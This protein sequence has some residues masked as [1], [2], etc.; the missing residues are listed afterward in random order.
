MFDRFL[1]FDH[2]STLLPS[3]SLLP[4]S[5]SFPQGGVAGLVICLFAK[6][7]DVR[8]WHKKQQIV[9]GR[10]YLYRLLYMLLALFFS[11]GEG[12]EEGEEMKPAYVSFLRPV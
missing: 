8:D 12:A 1:L 7:Q 4:L 10:N 2:S 6:L 11:Q 9:S 5:L 3:P